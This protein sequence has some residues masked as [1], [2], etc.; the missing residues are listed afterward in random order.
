MC[1]WRFPLHVLSK[2]TSWYK[3]RSEGIPET[4]PYKRTVT[5]WSTFYNIGKRLLAKQSETKSPQSTRHSKCTNSPTHNYV[6]LLPVDQP[7][8]KWLPR[9]DLRFVLKVNRRCYCENE[10]KI[11]RTHFWLSALA[12]DRGFIERNKHPLG[13]LIIM[14]HLCRRFVHDRSSLPHS[15]HFL[16]L[17]ISCLESLSTRFSSFW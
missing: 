16:L 1:I 3:S 11:C 14:D 4:C 13:P 17:Y 10:Q 15:F 7:S 5:M 9:S 12:C 2:Y 8:L 6:I